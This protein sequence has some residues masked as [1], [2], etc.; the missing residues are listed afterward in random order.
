VDKI[1]DNLD[2]NRCE[3][4]GSRRSE[5]RT[6]EDAVSEDSVTRRFDRRQ[7]LKR[8]GAGAA[9]AGLPLAAAPGAWAGLQRKSATKTLRIGNL[10]TLSGPNSAPPIDIKRGFVAYVQ[11]HDHRLG[12]RK[13]QFVDADDAGDPAT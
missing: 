8:A 9:V 11:A 13:I 5:R 1:R 7:V 12:G 6:K 4:V 10:L 3:R 2:D